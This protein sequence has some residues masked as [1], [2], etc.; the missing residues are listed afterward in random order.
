MFPFDDV[1]IADF[2]KSAISAAMGF[3]FY[4]HPDFIGMEST[5]VRSYPK[6]LIHALTLTKV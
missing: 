3:L 6:S 1:I 5:C 2:D 4:L